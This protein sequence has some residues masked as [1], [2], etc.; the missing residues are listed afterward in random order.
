MQNI[1]ALAFI[2]HGVAT[3][4][5]WACQLGLPREVVAPQGIK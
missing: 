1:S 2:V 4:A 5:R 3:A